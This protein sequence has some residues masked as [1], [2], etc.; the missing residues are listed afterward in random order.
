VIP[1]FL[2]SQPNIEGV[3]TVDY[4]KLG[5]GSSVEH[6]FRTGNEFQAF[7]NIALGIRAFNDKDYAKAGPF[8]CRGE[9]YLKNASLPGAPA[10]SLVQYVGD[11][12]KKAGGQDPAARTI[13]GLRYSTNRTVSPCE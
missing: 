2:S 11:L 10:A 13:R 12:R 9:Y 4:P 7:A 6:L 5:S 3:Y 8:L 1:L